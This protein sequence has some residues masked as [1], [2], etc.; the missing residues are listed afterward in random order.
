MKATLEAIR[1]KCDVLDNGCWVWH[2]STD[3]NK[4]P[5]MRLPNSRRLLN[6]RR[7]VLELEG[8]YLGNLKATTCCT[9]PFCVSPECVIASSPSELIRTAAKRTGYAQRPERCAQISA[10]KRK[11]SR[12]NWDLVNEIRTSPEATR[13]IARRLGFCQATIQSIRRGE[14]WKQYPAPA[15]NPLI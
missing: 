12:M 3:G 8:A 9:T 5:R 13:A 14:S 6:V 7:V 11:G 1:A 2:G 15:N 4:I 10:S